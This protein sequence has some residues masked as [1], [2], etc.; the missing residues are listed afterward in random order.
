MRAKMMRDWEAWLRRE[1]LRTELVVVHKVYRA[2]AELTVGHLSGMSWTSN[3][4]KT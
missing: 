3:F 1:T 2:F 4:T